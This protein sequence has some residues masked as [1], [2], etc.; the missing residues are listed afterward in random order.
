MTWS[1]LPSGIAEATIHP[2]TGQVVGERDRAM[3]STA[4][5]MPAMEI[6]WR[7]VRA[8]GGDDGRVP[9]REKDLLGSWTLVYFG[10]MEC[11]EACPIAMES[12]PEA[13]DQLNA[14]G[15]PTKAVFIDINA[16]RLDDLTG[17]WGIGDGTRARTAAGAWIR[18]AHAPWRR[19]SVTGPE[20]RRQAIA[21][22]GRQ[23]GPGHD[24]PVGHAQ[25]ADDRGHRLFQSRVEAAMMKN[26][27]AD[28]PHQSHDQ[29]LR[30]ESRR[31]MWPG[32]L[33]HSDSVQGD[34]SIL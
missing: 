15:M 31:A 5:V 33:Y 30:A 28:P 20:I 22:W 21:K 29:H 7:R 34:E 3:A 16:P 11:L 13:V 2:L 10:Y 1:T 19:E 25:A 6:A 18:H 26:A 17:G 9:S 14:A 24:L 27:R 12:M 4:Y 8:R 32:V 23:T